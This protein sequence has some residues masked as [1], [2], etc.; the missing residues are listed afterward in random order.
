[1]FLQSVSSRIQLEF[2]MFTLIFAIAALDLLMNSFLD[3]ALEYS[4]SGRLVKAGNLQN[5]GCIY[6]VVGSASHN[7]ITCD[8]ELIN[9]H[10]YCLSNVDTAKKCDGH[11][12]LYVA[13]KISPTPVAM[14]VRNGV[15]VEKL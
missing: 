3:F 2:N 8:L 1:M 9:R 13:E 11:T 14:V 5:M 7:M 12:L 15:A 10:L 6:P 4:R